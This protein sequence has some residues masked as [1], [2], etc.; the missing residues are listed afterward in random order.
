MTEVL[1]SINTPISGL[2]LTAPNEK[3]TYYEIHCIKIL[4]NERR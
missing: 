2:I 4:V 3:M 1:Q